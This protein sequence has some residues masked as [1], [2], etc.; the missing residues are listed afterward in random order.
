MDPV[1]AIIADRRARQLRAG[2]PA[3]PAADLDDLADE[4]DP[5]DA[6]AVGR[7]ERRTRR[8]WP[9]ADDLPTV[10]PVADVPAIPGGRTYWKVTRYGPD[11]SAYGA[12][13]VS[14]RDAAQRQAHQ[15]ARY[16]ST[17]RVT[18]ARSAA[19]VSWV[20]IEAL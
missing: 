18:I 11:G 4:L 13:V 15:W 9:V 7:R 3:P 17:A 10:P 20:D 6:V 16:A 14:H 2:L 8:G 5:V 12:R 19:P 1:D